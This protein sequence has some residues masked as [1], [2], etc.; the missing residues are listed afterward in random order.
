MAIYETPV[1]PET[2]TVHLGK[3]D[4]PAPNVEVPF[5]DYIKNVA[6]SEIYPTWPENAIRANIYAQISFALNRIYTEWYRSKGY[7]FD[8]T[9]STQYDQAYVQGRDIFDNISR[10]VDELFN[11]YVQ[12]HGSVEPYFT[13]YCNGTTSK[14]P[15]L[16]QWGTVPLAKQGLS[17]YQI[18]KHYYGNDINIV[19]D[20]PV[21]N[22]PESYPG[23]PLKLGMGSNDIKQIQVQLNRIRMNYPAIPRINYVDGVFGVETQSAVKAF[24]NIFQLASD[25]IVGKSTWYKI[26]EIYTGVKRLSELT[27]E[28][29][30]HGEFAPVV[31]TELIPGTV[32]ND[33][34]TIQYYLSVIG[35][36]NNNIPII[37][38]DGVYGP[39]TVNAV[40]QFQSY[41]GL[42]VTGVVDANT[43]KTMW[44]IYNDTLKSIPPS[45][46]QNAAVLYPGYFLKIGMENDDVKKMQ[47]YLNAV[48]KAYP[49]IPKVDPTGYFGEK[50][51]SSVKAFQRQFD[52]PESGIVGP[53]TWGKLAI[54]YDK[55][56]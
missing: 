1:I 2:I 47:G 6:S 5:V 15:G 27:S 34:R 32:S 4:Q 46:Y 52:L 48:A 33:V 49:A 38:I 35:Y 13:Q 31:V 29:I 17:P 44:K 20:A 3:P 12:K 43:W 10:T 51:L 11:D 54:Q 23:M 22:I 39:E 56:R 40:K 19:F 45:F 8:I 25:G 24:Q 7:N 42:P 21:E 53:A 16:S 41:Y 50:T 26:K 37:D 36:F 55:L 30:K 9:N 14:C 28:G 18:L